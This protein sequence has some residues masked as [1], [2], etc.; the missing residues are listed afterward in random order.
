[1]AERRFPLAEKVQQGDRNIAVVFAALGLGDLV[2]FQQLGVGV[3]VA[4][5]LD[6][7]VVRVVLVPGAMCLLGRWNWFPSRLTAPR[8]S[9]R[10][11]PFAVPGEQQRYE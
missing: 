2:M 4:L 5:L 9:H 7:T 3:A 11:P 10:A 1:L 8:R 6:A